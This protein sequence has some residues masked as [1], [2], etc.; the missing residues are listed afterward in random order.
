VATV[1][2]RAAW[3]TYVAAMDEDLTRDGQ[4]PTCDGKMEAEDDDAT[5]PITWRCGTCGTV[6]YED[7]T[8]QATSNG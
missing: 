7:D 2:Q 6:H 1:E 5:G 8:G 4:Q 3:T